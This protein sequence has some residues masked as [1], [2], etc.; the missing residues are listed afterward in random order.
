MKGTDGSRSENGDGPEAVFDGPACRTNVELCARS[1]QSRGTEVSERAVFALM[2]FF[3]FAHLHF[4]AKIPPIRTVQTSY[5]CHS[6]EQLCWHDVKQ[7][8]GPFD[9]AWQSR[10]VYKDKERWDGKHALCLPIHPIVPFSSD[11]MRGIWRSL[12]PSSL[13]FALIPLKI[14]GGKT[15][16][17]AKMT[18]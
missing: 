12:C 13:R 6:F 1:L 9:G 5:H 4:C 14:A 10:V 15:A 11:E 3:S 16:M 18:L 17:T 7:E 8:E 2:W